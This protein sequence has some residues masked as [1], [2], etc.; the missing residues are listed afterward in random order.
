LSGER[1]TGDETDRGDRSVLTDEEV[2]GQVMSRP[3]LTERRSLRSSLQ[4]EV[5]EGMTF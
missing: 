3:T 4:E 1:S 5:A 2:R